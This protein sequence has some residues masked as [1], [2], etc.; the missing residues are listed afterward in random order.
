MVRKFSAIKKDNVVHNV[1]DGKDIESIMHTGD[2][3]ADDD[4][5]ESAQKGLDV[6]PHTKKVTWR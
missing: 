1:D 3:I 4:S 6:K 2:A 5:N